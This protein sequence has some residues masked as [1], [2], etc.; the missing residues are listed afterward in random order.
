[1]VH[2]DGLYPW[3]EAH[4]SW[5]PRGLRIPSTVDPFFKDYSHKQGFIRPFPL[6]L[7]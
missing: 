1:M 6:K 5:T 7:Y 2:Y 4:M 3:L